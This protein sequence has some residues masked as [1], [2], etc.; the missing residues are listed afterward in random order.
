MVEDPSNQFFYTA[1]SE[2]QNVTGQVLDQ[3]SGVLTP[4]NQSSKV[5]SDYAL[6]GPPTWCLVDGRIGN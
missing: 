4:L 1:N 6:S 3:L 2:A 5:P